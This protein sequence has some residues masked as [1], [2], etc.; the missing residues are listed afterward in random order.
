MTSNAQRDEPT[1]TVTLHRDADDY[2]AMHFVIELMQ[3]QERA[4]FEPSGWKPERPIERILA[5]GGFTGGGGG[6]ASVARVELHVPLVPLRS[7]EVTGDRA[8]KAVRGMVTRALTGQLGGF[9][10]VVHG[11]VG[12]HAAVWAFEY[13]WSKADSPP[14]RVHHPEV[15]S[16]SP[17]DHASPSETANASEQNA[18]IAAIRTLQGVIPG[19]LA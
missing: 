1:M 14:I 2:R 13:L 12:F 17:A 8:I 18:T 3:D 6:D 15:I 7:F 4:R 19:G 10:P 11:Q 5:L 9:H 16:G